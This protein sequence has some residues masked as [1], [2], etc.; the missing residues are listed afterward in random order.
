MC[1]FVRYVTPECFLLFEHWPEQLLFHLNAFTFNKVGLPPLLNTKKKCLLLFL[2]KKNCKST[3]GH[4]RM[5]AE[6]IHCI[7]P[8]IPAI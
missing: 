3:A 6:G 8:V 4:E 7:L 1:A 2:K 5:T